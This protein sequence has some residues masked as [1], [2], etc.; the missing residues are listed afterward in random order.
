MTKHFKKNDKLLLMSTANEA[1]CFLLEKLIEI[2]KINMAFLA[3]VR[4]TG[5]SSNPTLND[6]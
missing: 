5:G 6:S 3:S 4:N 2:R 1:K